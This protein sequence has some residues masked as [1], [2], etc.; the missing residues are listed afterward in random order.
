[1]GP[2]ISY[3]TQAR[4]NLDDD[5]HAIKDQ[6]GLQA[7]SRF[8]LWLTPSGRITCNLSLFEEK[9]TKVDKREAQRLFELRGHTP[10]E[11]VVQR[12]QRDELL[13]TVRHP[14][15]KVSPDLIAA[16][17]QAVTDYNAQ[18]A[19]LYPLPPIQRLGYLDEQDVIECKR[20][21]M[22][23]PIVTVKDDGKAVAPKARVPKVIFRKGEKYSI[24]TQTVN[25]TR[26]TM[27]PNPFTGM[28]EECEHSGQELAI[29]LCDGLVPPGEKIKD[30][31]EYCFMDASIMSDPET[32]V[33]TGASFAMNGDM[34]T[35]IHFSLQQLADHFVIPDVP[36]VA[37][38][39]PEQ[40]RKNLDTL[41]ELESITT[42]LTA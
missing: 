40:Y 39:H 31:K 34:S 30:Q 29:Y 26:T 37:T 27:K 24:R 15:W 21:L 19:P 22:G 6:I 5:W 42:A 35:A 4:K 12:A 33:K 14:L 2:E 11:L 8:N 25:V 28:S 17:N 18:R 10:M 13:H 1:M 32:K 7:G 41:V 9:S 36:D 16:V 3:P 20:D 23:L 38:V